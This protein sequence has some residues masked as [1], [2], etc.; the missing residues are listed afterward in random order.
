MKC[1]KPMLHASLG[2]VELKLMLYN[3][4]IWFWRCFLGHF[5][6]LKL[7]NQSKELHRNLYFT[8]HYFSKSRD[9]FFMCISISITL[10][11]L[12]FWSL[13]QD[14]GVGWLIFTKF[15]TVKAPPLCV[16]RI[17]HSGQNKLD[18]NFWELG[19]SLFLLER[20]WIVK[21]KYGSEMVKNGNAKKQTKIWQKIK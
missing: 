15:P 20:D 4:S 18:A 11:C 9:F 21:R 1:A 7:P 6:I 10:L 12:L 16:I 2:R 19:C 5:C 14:C 8:S 17:P 3:S 13:G